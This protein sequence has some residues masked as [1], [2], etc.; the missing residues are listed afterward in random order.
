MSLN[1]DDAD[2]SVGDGPTVSGELIDLVMAMAGRSDAC[3]MLTG[4]GVDELRQ[5]MS[6]S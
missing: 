1:A 3:D 6:R 5:R 2:F 4:D